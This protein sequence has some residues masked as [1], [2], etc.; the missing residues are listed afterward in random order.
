MH[1][2]ELDQDY[3][4]ISLIN[5]EQ[6][7]Q[8]ELHKWIRSEQAGKDLSDEA[9]LEWLEKYA[10]LFRAWSETIPYVCIKC[11]LCEGRVMCDRPFEPQRIR[12]LN[13]LSERG[14]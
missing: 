9:V 8:I 7:R 4:H 5:K 10:P 1:S 13:N 12:H 2:R 11:G 6:L 3:D 14:A